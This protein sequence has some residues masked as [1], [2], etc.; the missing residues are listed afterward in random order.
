MRSIRIRATAL[1]ALLFPILSIPAFAA[2]G[3]L[4]INP[5]CALQTG[6]F[7]GDSAGFP[8]TIDGSAGR[9]YRLTA[10]LALPDADTTG[11]SISAPDVSLDLGGFAIRGVVAC[12]GSPTSCTAGGAGFGISV[13]TAA[14]RVHI[15]H[16]GI[17]GMGADGIDID[18]NGC[19]V[20]D[21]RVGSNK[22]DGIDTGNA[23]A[24]IVRESIAERNGNSGILTGLRSTVSGNMVSFNGTNGIGTLSGNTLSGNTV[25][26]NGATGISSGS[27]STVSGNTAYLNT[28]AGI[29]ISIGS[30][31]SGNTAHLNAGDGIQTAAGSFVIGN[32]VRDN[33]GAGLRLGD[34]SGYRENLITSN[35]AGTVIVNSGTIFNM[36]N[37]ACTDNLNATAVCP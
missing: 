25:S 16:G 10:D 2:D 4:E 20:S 13:S 35:A 22:L 12:S 5:T 29:S 6:C 37:N 36:G 9:S 23:S 30:T 17:S 8:V 26:T 7:A 18:G 31:A 34:D 3:V 14:P 28:A 32:G 24:C 21:V 1:T 33:N 19:V 11:V 15:S 27:G